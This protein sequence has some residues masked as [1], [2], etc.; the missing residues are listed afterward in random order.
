M[1]LQGAEGVRHYGATVRMG[2]APAAPR[3]ISLGA[4]EPTAWTQ[5]D[6]YGDLLFHG[7]AFQVIRDI[8]GVSA[9]GI[10]GTL[11]GLR[12]RQWPDAPWQVD[13]A[14]IDGAIQLALL[15]GAKHLGGRSLPT[16]I[17][18]FVPH[19]PGA[20]NGPLRC[21]VAARGQGA[22]SLVADVALSDASGALVATMSGLEMHLR[23]AGT[24]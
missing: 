19:R 12:A 20:A 7:P 13:V 21:V 10:A 22:H 4:L 9:D 8:E 24:R 11:D 18:S 6:L 14:A 17:G 5:D 1:V 15:W 16:R 3:P 2:T 23:I